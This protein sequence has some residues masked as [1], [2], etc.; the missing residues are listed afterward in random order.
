MSRRYEVEQDYP[1]LPTVLTAAAL[2]MV[3]PF[4]SSFLTPRRDRALLDGLSR[5]VPTVP[6]LPAV[7]LNHRES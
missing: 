4:V 6:A 7:P 5:A 1:R 2:L 3:S